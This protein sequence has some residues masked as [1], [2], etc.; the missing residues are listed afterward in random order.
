MKKQ[1]ILAAVGSALTLGVAQAQSPA[2]DDRIQSN[3]VQADRVNVID[4][5][6]LTQERVVGGYRGVDMEDGR[7]RAG[8][9]V[10]NEAARSFGEVSG[11]I[12]VMMDNADIHALA[13]EFGLNVVYT[14]SRS[15]IGQLN[16]AGHDD[17]AGLLEALKASGMVRAARLDIVEALYTSDVISR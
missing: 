5:T 3:A 8:A 4:R 12:T 6:R 14:D 15:G 2:V 16:A 17:L 11:N 13:N 9:Q 7:L 1:L 10:Y